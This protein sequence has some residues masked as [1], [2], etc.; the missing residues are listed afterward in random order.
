MFQNDEWIVIKNLDLDFL[1]KDLVYI[2]NKYLELNNLAKTF[3]QPSG[4]DE[5]KH[6]KTHLFVKYYNS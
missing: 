4:T 1:L 3:I 6:V 2:R 5:L